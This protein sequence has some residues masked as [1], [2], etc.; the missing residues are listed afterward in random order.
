[1]LLSGCSFWSGIKPADPEV[2]LPP[3]T[4]TGANTFGCKVNGKVLLPKSTGITPG[5][6]GLSMRLLSK[7]H[8]N[9]IAGNAA[10]DDF[11]MVVLNI[12]NLATGIFNLEDTTKVGDLFITSAD[13]I[14]N[15]IIYGDGNRQNKSKGWIKITKCDKEKGIFS[16]TFEFTLYAT[17][18]LTERSVEITEGRFDVK[19]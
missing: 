7:N 17:D 16:G 14:D 4:Q 18:S 5:R 11:R 3:E 12:R 1:M 15:N 9:I 8:L 2:S 10:D 6:I 19:M 13:Y